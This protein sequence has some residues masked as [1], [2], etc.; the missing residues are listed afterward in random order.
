MTQTAPQRASARPQPVEVA[1]VAGNLPFVIRTFLGMSVLGIGANVFGVVVVALVVAAMNATAN[2]HQLTVILATTGGVVLLSVLVGV[3]AGV[4]VQRRTLRWLLRGESPSTADARRA[5]RMPRDMSVI[6]AVLWF[7]GGIV[8][9]AV[10]GAVGEDATTTIGIAGGIVIAGLSSAGITYLLIRRVSGP[11]ARLALASCPPETAPVLGV[12]W[13]LLLNWLLTSAAPVLGLVLILTAPSG[14]SHIVGASIVVAVVALVL[15]GASTALAARAIG[16]PLRGMVD[17]LHRVGAGDLDIIVPIED[18][19]EIGLVQAGFNDMV[20]GL[21][22]RDRVTDLFGRH[23]GSSVAQVAL[24]SGVTL[25]GELRDVVAVFVDIT[26]SMRRT[27]DTD[28]VEFVGMLNRFYEIVVDE[29]EGAGGLLN[30]FEGDAALCVFGAP[31]ELI[32]AAAA[33]LGAA[34]RIRDRVFAMGEVE[35]GVGV[36][37][38]PVVA[39]Q[40]GT[41]SRLEYTVIGDAVNEAARLTALS[42]EMRQHL[43]ASADVIERLTGSEGEHWLPVGSV[44]LKG[45]DVPTDIWTA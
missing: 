33:A 6:A 20:A 9:S 16:E 7:T 8:I 45:R 2:R 4:L 30:K 17:V 11:I 36:A 40:V 5:L 41:R 19:G 18:A 23:V 26:D 44:V 21:R 42:K 25:S 14:K 32:D 10:A 38:G 31:V 3:T 37:A 12:R 15:G 34:R 28:P 13:Q 43:L 29:V 1:L 39:G 24:R 27:R 35:V 22:E